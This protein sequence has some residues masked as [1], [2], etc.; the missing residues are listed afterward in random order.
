VARAGQTLN[1]WKGRASAPLPVLA[2]VSVGST[3]AEAPAATMAARVIPSSSVKAVSACRIQAVGTTPAT[4]RTVN[5]AVL[6][7]LIVL[8]TSAKTAWMVRAPVR[9]TALASP[10]ATTAAAEPAEPVLVTKPATRTVHASACPIVSAMASAVTTAVAKPAATWKGLASTGLRASTARASTIQAVGTTPATWRT[11]NPAVLVSPTAHVR[12]EKTAWMVR[13]PVRPTAL[14]SPVATTAAAEPAEPVLVTKPAT[15]TVHA[16]ACPIVLATVSA[17]TTAVAKPAATMAARVIPSSSVKA[18]S[19]CRIQAVGTTPATWRTVR[20]A[21]LVSLIALVASAKTAW[22]VRA[23]VRPTALASPVATTA[24]A[25]PAEPVLATK[26]ATRMVHAS[27]CPIVSAMASAVTTAAAELVA[28]MAARVT[29]SSSAKTGPA[30]RIQAAGTLPA[31]WRT[32][33]PAEL[34]SP[35]ALVASEK[36]VWTGRVPAR[37]TALTRSAATMAVAEPV[38]TGAAA[39]PGATPVRSKESAR[40]CSRLWSKE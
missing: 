7:S 29:P 10:V 20:P 36:T 25:E 26:P 2:T 32:V 4:W 31:T 13:A 28:K 40:R 39:A 12:M 19:A 3:A 34:V 21:V 37:Q 16:S 18:V 35:I 22:M 9:P 5:P 23:P 6:V 15:R 38:A 14:T 11:V 30:F 24:A 27:A 33:R 1:A 8:A 17:V